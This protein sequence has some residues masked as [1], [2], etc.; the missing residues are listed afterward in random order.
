MLPEL[1]DETD[2]TDMATTPRNAISEGFAGHTMSGSSRVLDSRKSTFDAVRKGLETSNPTVG[3]HHSYQSLQLAL[4]SIETRE[5]Q[6]FLRRYFRHILSIMLDQ[7]PTKV[8]EAYASHF[9][10]SWGS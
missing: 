8:R 7:L 4:G 3:W 6:D 2:L 1:E 9:H 10:P 5:S